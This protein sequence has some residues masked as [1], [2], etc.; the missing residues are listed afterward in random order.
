[1]MSLLS[2]SVPPPARERTAGRTTCGS[3]GRTFCDARSLRR[4]IDSGACGRSRQPPPVYSKSKHSPVLDFPC[5][6]CREVFSSSF[7]LSSHML[8]HTHSTEHYTHDTAT[9]QLTQFSRARLV[10]DY[11][12]ESSEPIVDI[13]DF[14]N[15]NINLIRRMF[16][17]LDSFRVKALIYM[18]ATYV[19]V[20]Q[21]SGEVID[22]ASFSFISKMADEVISLEDWLRRHVDGLNDK[23]E[24]FNERDSGW[25]FVG[26]DNFQFKI[27]LLE[28]HGGSGTFP[29][30]KDLLSKKAV[31]NVDCESQCFKYA[32][33]AILHYND[34]S[35]HRHRI[36]KYSEWEDELSFEGIDDPNNMKFK[37]IAKFEKLNKIKIVVH[38]WQNKLIGS[39][40]NSR[41]SNYERVVNLL[42]VYKE[43][44]PQWH[45]C[46]IPSVKRLYNHKYKSATNHKTNYICNRCTQR[47]VSQEKFKT[48]Y[49]W[50]LRGKLQ[51]ET[52]PEEK[53][54]RYQE[55]GYGLSPI[56]I[57]YSDIECYIDP[58]T[59]EHRP[60][61]IGCLEVWH[62]HFRNKIQNKYSK[63]TGEDCVEQF[64]N[65]LDKKA[66]F[67]HKYASELMRKPMTFT[68]ADKIKFDLCHECPTCHHAF[69]D[70]EYKKVRDHCHLSGKFRT[71]LCHKCNLK[72][73]LPTT[74]SPHS[75]S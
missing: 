6:V 24:R 48:H 3:C 11:R 1:M 69:D 57:I 47:F 55:N 8:T 7:L 29:L 41:S 68:E 32:V 38:L 74:C 43:G 10:R 15:G 36:S 35:Q 61:S 30:P 63:W 72:A 54:Y 9:I 70:K 33:L 37:D 67:L 2:F 17:P 62:E 21:S 4:H 59:N 58:D 34:I 44:T 45:Y 75:I 39:R 65:Y 31:I 12:M 13:G 19:K 27:T 16:E 52:M 14:L 46:A 42:L 40:Y 64:L 22:T 50:C 28:N 66:H 49:E 60:A 53:E 18:T 51:T 5:A 23:L 26:I 73:S 71:A 20:N 56:C 25:I